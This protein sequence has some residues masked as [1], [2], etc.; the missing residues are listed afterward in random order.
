VVAGTGFFE[1]QKGYAVVHTVAQQ[2]FGT[3]GAQINTQKWT[4]VV[5]K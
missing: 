2:L 3:N 1:G 5:G 4:L